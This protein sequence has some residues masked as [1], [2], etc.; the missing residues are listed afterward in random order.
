MAAILITIDNIDFVKVH[1]RAAFPTVKS[2]HMTE[3]L[4]CGF[5]YRS[6]AALLAAVKGTP[7]E[8]PLLGK[9]DDARIAARLIE[10]GH[11]L[12]EPVS[13]IAAARSPGLP[14]R[15]WTEFPNRDRYANDLWFSECRHRNIPN[16]R[17]EKRRKY[18]ELHWDCIS[19]DPRDEGHTR[20]KSGSALVR[21]LFDTFQAIARSAHGKPL[22]HGSSFVG[23]V[24]RLTPEMARTMADAFFAMLYLP[25]QARAEAA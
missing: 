15:I 16:L 17:I 13:T 25:M 24:D 21:E 5:G 10:L 18:A 3:A 14:D 2:A 6:H 4:A 23:S 9:I 22:F 11:D 19:I 20:G 8:R 7:L 1:L 12:T